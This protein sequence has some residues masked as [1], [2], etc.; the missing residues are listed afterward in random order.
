MDAGYRKGQ[1]LYVETNTENLEGLFHS[2]DHNVMTLTDVV[3]H[4][5]EK[6][7]KGFSNFYKSEI[8]YGKFIC[9]HIHV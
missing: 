5:S 6:E 2:M 4:P 3:L 7:I 8:I 1:R 9:Q